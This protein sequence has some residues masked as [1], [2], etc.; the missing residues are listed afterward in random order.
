MEDKLSYEIIAAA[1]K[2]HNTLG[3]GFLEKVY[4]NAMIHEL[5]KK[6]INASPQFL[7]S[8][9]YDDQLVGDYKADIFVENKIIIE[10]K[11]TRETTLKDEVQLVNYLN[12]A[13][14]HFGL[15][16]NF[17]TSVTVKRKYQK[18]RTK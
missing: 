8:V 18:M 14:I 9:Y 15:L 16:I 6:G 1:Y 5:R 3:F 7:I 12:G 13:K 10:L 2:V 4:E 17:G 11:S